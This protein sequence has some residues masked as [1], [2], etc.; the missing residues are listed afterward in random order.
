M[1]DAA[2]QVI[3]WIRRAYLLYRA[4]F[5][6]LLCAGLL[7]AAV[8]PL[9]AFVLPVSGAHSVVQACVVLAFYFPFAIGLIK[10][11]LR[12][13]DEGA[14]VFETGVKVFLFDGF[15]YYW[16]V[17]RLWLL[18]I[19]AFIPLYASVEIALRGN[20]DTDALR[21]WCIEAVTVLLIPCQYFIVDRKIGTLKSIAQG[22]WLWKKNLFSLLPLGFAD[23][24]VALIAKAFAIA[25]S[26]V[27]FD[28]EYFLHAGID[29]FWIPFA[30]VFLAVAFRC[31][32]ESESDA[33]AG[34]AADAGAPVLR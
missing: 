17:F 7:L 2:A 8:L 14:I 1:L 12:M 30:A 34:A 15:N 33:G 19:V 4:N 22:F 27:L 10:L 20:I 28:A 32:T 23:Q 13:A 24:I 29:I 21:R 11:S 9:F 31:C 6:L 3:G 16:P 25:A 26:P 5:A 18:A